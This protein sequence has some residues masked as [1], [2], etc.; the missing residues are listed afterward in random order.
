[1]KPRFDQYA[2]K[3]DALSRRERTMVLVGGVAL[4]LALFYYL[5]IGPSLERSRAMRARIADQQNQLVAA[6]AQRAEL[7]TAS[8]QDPDLATRQRIVNK[9]QQ[10]ADIDG[11]LTGLQRTLVSPQGMS[12]VL[13]QLVGPDV[14]VRVLRLRNLP[15]TPLVEKPAADAAATPAPAAHATGRHVYKHGLQ[16]LVEGS[17]LDVLA[18]VARLEQQPWQVYWGRTVMT[19]DYP[20][21]HVELTLYTLSLEQ[22]WLAV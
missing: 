11:Q 3:L 5:G 2:A 17:Y 9:K 21:V 16:V 13:A 20:A 10:L 15:P 22:T 4:I 1:M 12:A 14:R 18:Y 8:K 7:E 6:T 19:A